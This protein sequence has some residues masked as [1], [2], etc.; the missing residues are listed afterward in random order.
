MNDAWNTF[1]DEQAQLEILRILLDDDG[2]PGPDGVRRQMPSA[3][4]MAE[5]KAQI[6]ANLGIEAPGNP[7]TEIADLD[8]S[9]ALT[10]W[11][12]ELTLVS[13]NTR[14]A[15]GVDPIT[16]TMWESEIADPAFLRTITGDADA[17]PLIV[18]I[19]VAAGVIEVTIPLPTAPVLAGSLAAVFTDAHGA[20]V[21]VP[22]ALPAA[23]PRQ[24]AKLTGRADVPAGFADQ[25]MSLSFQ[26]DSS[27]RRR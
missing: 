8:L 13:S 14:T 3:E 6:R 27:G 24:P 2:G 11:T 23:A 9:L 5:A 26:T 22:L 10:L 21:S 7:E 4:A 15:G 17:D 12:A 20:A 1:D 19:E 18:R 25:N 16:E